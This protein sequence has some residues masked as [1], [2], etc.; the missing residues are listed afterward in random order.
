MAA[1][2]NQGHLMAMGNVQDVSQYGLETWFLIGKGS[3]GTK[4]WAWESE[5]TLPNLPIY[6][7]Q[8]SL[9]Y[10]PEHLYSD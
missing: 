5:Y 2:I 9:L 7:H 3:G 10:V 6:H 8:Q 1:P 4:L